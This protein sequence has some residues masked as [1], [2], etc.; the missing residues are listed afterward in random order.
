M[1]FSLAWIG[2]KGEDPQL[3]LD[4]LHFRSTGK[5][6]ECPDSPFYSLT[7]GDWYIV[8]ADRSQVE[9]IL[10]AN[11]T[12]IS[13]DCDLVFCQVEEHVMYSAAGHWRDTKQKWFLT[14]NP[15]DGVDSLKE[16]GNLPPEY[17][18]I[19]DRNRALQQ[20]EVQENEAESEAGENESE[21]DYIFEIPVEVAE[22]ITGFRHDKDLGTEMKF[23]ILT[24]EPPLVQAQK[25]WWKKLLP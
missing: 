1:G 10:N 4:R 2:V 22:S 19:R 24:Y 25:P 5:F 7:L 17:A 3:I 15:E 16:E 12:R 18:A 9:P 8:I 20:A 13:F 21:V 11:P 6:E 14:H 23:E